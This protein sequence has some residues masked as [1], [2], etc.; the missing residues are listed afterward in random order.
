MFEGN[1]SK[2]CVTAVVMA[3]AALVGGCSAGDVELNGSVFDT[4]GVGSKAQS[5]SKVAQAPIRQGLVVPP[6]LERLPQ[7]GS[8]SADAVV[9]T[10]AMPVDPEQRRV[11]SAAQAER[12]HRA[13]CEKALQQARINRDLSPVKG[14][15]GRCDGSV[16]DN[17]SV[18]SPVEFKTGANPPPKTP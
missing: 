2:G 10:E 5:S 12:E 4:L 11:A 9:A 6:D 13:Y 14:P 17:I 18:N 8:G 16:L 15:L 3:F 1:R 7:P